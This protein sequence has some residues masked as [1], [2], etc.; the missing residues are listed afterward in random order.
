MDRVSN[1]KIRV[2][3]SSRVNFRVR[4]SSVSIPWR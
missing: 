4:V 2:N 1:V 3:R